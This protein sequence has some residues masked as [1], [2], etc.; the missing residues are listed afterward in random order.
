MSWLNIDSDSDFSIQN[1]PMG[2]FSTPNHSKRIGVAI[3]DYV[4]DLNA[5]VVS[6]IFSNVSFDS[7]TLKEETLNSFMA[8]NRSCWRETRALVKG[9]LEVNGNDTRLQIL[10]FHLI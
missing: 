1:L 8:L 2:V 7:K 6:G 5:L 4:L 10:I 9:L 3:G